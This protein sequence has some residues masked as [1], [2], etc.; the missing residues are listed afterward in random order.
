MSFKFGSKS[1]ERM[2]GVDDRLIAIANRAIQLTKVDFGIPEYGG[3][4]T[5]EDQKVLFERGVTKADGVDKKSYHQTGKALDVYAW[6]DSQASWDI[7]Y[8]AQIAA[9]MLQ[10]AIELGYKIKWGGLWTSF[11]DTPHFEIID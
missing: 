9:A 1:I 6:V 3:L 7:K 8:M 4:R 2:S 5:V 11:V 10:A